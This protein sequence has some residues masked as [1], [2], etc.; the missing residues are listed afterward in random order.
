MAH[1][2]NGFVSGDTL[3]LILDWLDDDILDTEFEEEIEQEAEEVANTGQFCCTSCSK[4]YKTKGGLSHHVNM[5]HNAEIKKADELEWETFDSILS[6]TQQ[7]IAKTNAIKI[8]SEGKL[9]PLCSLFAKRLGDKLFA[10][11]KKPVQGP[12]EKPPPITS[13][14][15]GGLQFLSDQ[16]L[17]QATSQGGLTAV[18]QNMQQIFRTA[19]EKFRLETSIQ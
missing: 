4:V 12:T 13:K 6:N 11:A 18:S 7:A 15:M 5:K 8:M 19:E 14:G 3:D 9:Q 1:N 17:I 2:A 10:N 16:P